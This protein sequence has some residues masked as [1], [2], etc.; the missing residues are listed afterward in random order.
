MSLRRMIRG[1]ARRL[2]MLPLQALDSHTRAEALDALSNREIAVGDAGGA[3]LRFYAPS[4]L[5]QSRANTVLSKEPDTIAW[6]NTLQPD[7]VF[8]DIGANV[9]VFTL[10]AAVTRSCQ[11]VAF[12]ASAP[13]FFVLTR[14]VQLNGLSDRITPYGLAVAERTQLGTINLDSAELGAAMSQ[15]GPAGVKSRYSSAA[16]PLMHGVAAVTIDDL[17][18]RF[19]APRPT[20]IKID[21]DGLE[22]P[23]LRGGEQTLVHPGMRSVMVELC[24]THEA[25]RNDAISWLRDRGLMLASTGAPQGSGD[26][27]AA[28]HLFV[29]RP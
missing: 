13:N 27:R 2:A 9:G 15:F 17:V 22:W 26:E 4:P 23:I 24:L 12:E 19:Q 21:V 29:R 10:Y 14:N 16:V 6:L 1:V 25:E 3:I 28:N 5:L 7:D 8:W 20:A 11:V 18:Q